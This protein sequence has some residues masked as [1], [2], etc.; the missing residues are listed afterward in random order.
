MW[1]KRNLFHCYYITNQNVKETK[2]KKCNNFDLQNDLQYVSENTYNKLYDYMDNIRI[3]YIEP[4][5]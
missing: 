2:I 1:R 3:S 5:Q 4:Q